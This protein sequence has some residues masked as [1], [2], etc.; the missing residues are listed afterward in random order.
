MS[1]GKYIVLEGLDGSG[2]TTQY[3][4]IMDFLGPKTLGVREPGGTAIAEEIRT[5]LKNKA[6]P[7]APSTNIFLFSAAR[8]D[9]VETVIRPNLQAGR[10]V[11][12]DRNWLSTVAYQ[13]AEGAPVA[14][15]LTLSQLATKECFE[16]DLL[17]LIDVSPEVCEQRLSERGGD[18]DYFETKGRAYFTKV[19]EAYLAHARTLKNSE[20]IDGHQ[21]PEAVWAAIHAILVEKGWQ[22]AI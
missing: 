11:V 9:L 22:G 15:I 14:D 13:Q 6:L 12:S 7:R 17:L 20:I 18:A 1:R 3:A 10:H 5:L 4:R 2:K 21:S 19:R 16:P 8:T